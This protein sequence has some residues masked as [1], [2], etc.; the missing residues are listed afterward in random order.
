METAPPEFCLLWIEH[1]STCMTKSE[2]AGWMQAI[3]TVA[4]IAVAIAIPWK[5]VQRAR[6]QARLG[7]LEMIATD[8]RLAGRQARV[9]LDNIKRFRLPAYRL[10]LHGAHTALPSLLAD[11][12]LN[13]DDATALSQFY[14]DATSFNYCLDIAQ[15]LK[16]QNLA[17]G[18][19]VSRVVKKAEHLV[20]ASGR[21]RYDRAIAVLRKHLPEQA[22]LRLS[23]D[24]A[25]DYGAEVEDGTS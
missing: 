25:E 11:G 8:V 18:R 21:S 16:N 19:E 5:Q 2:W 22:V 3:G 6:S 4:A 20:P 9:Y 24:A 14:V 13:G 1:W 15:G 23:I 12:T 17:W 7:H 10:Q